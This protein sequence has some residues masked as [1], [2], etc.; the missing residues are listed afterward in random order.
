MAAVPPHTN[1]H[2]SNRHRPSLLLA[3][4]LRQ[5]E[6]L[7]SIVEAIS[8]DDA[9]LLIDRNSPRIE[10]LA[11]SWSKRAELEQEPSFT[12]EYLHSTVDAVRDDDA[13]LLIDRHS[14]RTVELAIS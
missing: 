12:R 2:D 9:A 10:E 4:L 13:A 3:L 8:D 1:I 7:H 5:R 11:I 14:M 6:Y